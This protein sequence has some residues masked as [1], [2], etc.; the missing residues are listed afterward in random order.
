MG[1]GFFIVFNLSNEQS[2]NSIKKWIDSLKEEMENPKIVI[3]GHET[4]NNNNIPDKII[5]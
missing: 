4:Q 5:K 3:L 1:E 2:L